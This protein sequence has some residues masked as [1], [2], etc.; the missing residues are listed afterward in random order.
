MISTFSNEM[1]RV[2]SRVMECMRA[3]LHEMDE[4]ENVDFFVSGR[5]KEIVISTFSTWNWVGRKSEWNEK[6]AVI[7]RIFNR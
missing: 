6:N 4:T 1:G 3:F 5:G 2:F 7:S